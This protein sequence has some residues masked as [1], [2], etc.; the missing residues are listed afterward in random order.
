MA[1]IPKFGPGSALAEKDA[2]GLRRLGVIRPRA[3]LC[4]T[5]LKRRDR[6]M[7]SRL[8]TSIRQKPGGG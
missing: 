5:R 3:A 4:A 2:E 7:H 6:I 8:K 1:C